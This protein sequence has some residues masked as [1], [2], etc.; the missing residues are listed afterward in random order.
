MTYNLYIYDEA[1]KIFK[2]HSDL[3][4]FLLQ[5]IKGT[6]R[7]AHYHVLWDDNNLTMDQLQEFTYNM[8]HVYSRC[9]KSV[10]LPAPVAYAHL[11][12]FR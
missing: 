4:T 12:A 1:M 5:G 2:R 11:A 9:S 6:S 10:S 7:P 3:L 8:C